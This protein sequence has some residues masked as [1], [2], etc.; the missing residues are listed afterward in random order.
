MLKVHI[1]GVGDGDCIVIELPDGRFGLIDSYILPGS[2]VS[3][4]LDILAGKELAFCCLTHPD[5]DHLLGMADIIR[6]KNIDVGEFW[7]A[8]SDLHGILKIWTNPTFY[9]G[10]T[11]VSHRWVEQQNGPLVD[12][13]DAVAD[14]IKHENLKTKLGVQAQDVGGVQ[15]VV[16]GPDDATWNRYRARLDRARCECARVPKRYNNRLSICILMRYGDHAI[17]L[18]GDLPRAQLRRLPTREHNEQLPIARMGA[19]ASMLKVPHH[20]AADGLF[21]EI[22]ETLMRDSN[23]DVV[24]FSASGSDMHPHPSVWKYWTE[25]NKRIAATWTGNADPSESVSSG[26]TAHLVDQCT[27][28]ICESRPRDVLITVPSSGNIAVEYLDS[29][30]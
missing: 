23:N 16:F 6:A 30:D 9:G 27:R 22:S 13:F 3:P 20:G 10:S 2:D 25:T 21:D 17:W 8:L 1:C 4:A 26:A 14:E 7:Y 18:L 15:F 11:P 5:K 12:L 19:Q 28:P 29:D 24:A